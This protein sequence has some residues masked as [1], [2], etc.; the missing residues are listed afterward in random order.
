MN[1]QKLLYILNNKIL[2]NYEQI[3]ERTKFIII[4]NNIYNILGLNLLFDD[5]GNGWKKI[6]ML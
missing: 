2:K 4:F 5:H 3:S 6:I 1:I